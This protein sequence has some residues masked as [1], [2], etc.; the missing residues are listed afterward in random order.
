M[1]DNLRQWTAELEAAGNSEKIEILSRFFKTGKGEYAEGDRFI[2]VTVPVN[3][4]ISRRYA[5]SSFDDIAVMI[6]SD[7]HE[8]RLSA[9]LALVERYEKLKHREQRDETTDF[10][11]SV[12]HKADNWDLVDLSA[13]KILGEEI[14]AGRRLSDLER[15][16]ESDCLWHNRIAM[17]SMLTPVMRYRQTDMALDIAER[18]ISHPHDLMR[19]AV[20]WVLREIGKKDIEALRGFLAANISR[21]SAI[22]L[23]YATEKLPSHERAEWRRMRK[24]ATTL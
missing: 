11:L 1:N 10:Y 23:S 5:C 7:I 21:I 8:F 19:K 15:L 9:L 20:G 18:F 17:V 2:G 13:P 16:I 12:G 4:A 24:S 14:A 22:T 3:R 6:S